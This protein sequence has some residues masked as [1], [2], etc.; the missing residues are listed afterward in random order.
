M[1]DRR[2]GEQTGTLDLRSALA[3]DPSMLMP[4]RVYRIRAAASAD[5][6]IADAESLRL[7]NEALW[8]ADGRGMEATAT[9]ETEAVE[10]WQAMT[11]EVIEVPAALL[12]ERDP[13]RAEIE[14]AIRAVCVPGR[15]AI[16]AVGFR[17]W[18]DHAFVVIYTEASGPRGTAKW[19]EAVERA[20]AEVLANA[21]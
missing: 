16:V 4:D 9:N 14:R 10:K 7:A 12:D 6:R 2:S 15:P 8:C 13:R 21:A 5:A 1:N 19:Y 20:T 11:I 17:A 18:E 3:Y